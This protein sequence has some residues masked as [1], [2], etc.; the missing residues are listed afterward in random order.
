MVLCADGNIS[1]GAC[2][3]RALG[4]SLSTPILMM[5]SGVLGNLLALVILFTADRQVRRT[6]F[7]ALLAGMACTDL[8]GQA[9]NGVVAIIVYA[10][11][12]QWVGGRPVCIYHGFSMVFF[13]VV[14]PQLVCAM[15]VERLLALRF[16]YFYCRQFTNRI[17]KWIIVTVWT[18]TAFFCTWPL[19]GFGSYELQFPGSWCFLNFHRQTLS[20]MIYA[21]VFSSLNI[22]IIA[23][24]IICN[25]SV[26]CTLL[27]MRRVRHMNSSPSSSADLNRHVHPRTR[28]SLHL[29]METQMVWF[30]VA[31]TIV[32]SCLWLPINVHI[33]TNQ[34]NGEINYKQDLISVRLA[35]INQ[36]VDPWMYVILRKNTIMKFLRHVKQFFFRDG[37]GARSMTSHREQNT[38]PLVPLVTMRQADA[39]TGGATHT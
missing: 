9:A 27:Q 1:D 8:V 10:N 26:V 38:L 39:D 15:S 16:S 3:N 18:A 23:A 21:L 31:I 35:S 11:R 32:F 17:A 37:R 25:A 33:L 28:P 7:F 20:D 22:V 12:L 34:I 30:L 4:I 5:S 29:E 14:T 36:I 19:M 2:D 24:I 13:A 6:P